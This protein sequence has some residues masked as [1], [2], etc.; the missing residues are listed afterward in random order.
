MAIDTQEIIKEDELLVDR[1]VAA[2][3]QVLNEVRKVIV[4]QDEVID[5]RTKIL[6]PVVVTRPALSP[7]RTDLALTSRSGREGSAIVKNLLLTFL[8]GWLLASLALGCG[9]SP[10]K[11]INSG[12]D[13]PKPA[14][15]K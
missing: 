12:K 14:D 7:S 1:L 13:K 4:G 5:V 6:G 11:G 2:R 3:Q 15:M 9:G 8:S 10:P